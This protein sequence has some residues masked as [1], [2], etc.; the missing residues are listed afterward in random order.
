[1]NDYQIGRLIQAGG[2]FTTT[3]VCCRKELA[4]ASNISYQEAHNDINE[5]NIAD[6]SIM[7]VERAIQLLVWVACD[8][9]EMVNNA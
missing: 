9:H 1:M 8:T 7:G 6:H 3:S 5:L 2:R 4:V